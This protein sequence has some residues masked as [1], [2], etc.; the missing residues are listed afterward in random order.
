MQVKS[1]VY[2][3]FNTLLL[4]RTDSREIIYTLRLGQEYIGW[5]EYGMGML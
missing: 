4:I 3:F 5:I 2:A 1:I